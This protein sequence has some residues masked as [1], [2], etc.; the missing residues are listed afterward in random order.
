M[1]LMPLL[2]E[3]LWRSMACARSR[4]EFGLG[5]PID[6]VPHSHCTSVRLVNAAPGLFADPVAR[7]GQIMNAQ[8]T[9]P[10]RHTFATYTVDL[11]LDDGSTMS[12]DISCATF[13]SLSVGDKVEVQAQVGL[14]AIPWCLGD[15]VLPGSRQPPP[16]V[17]CK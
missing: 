10:K 3:R 12:L 5:R 9:K 17:R 1:S 15:C 2:S 7:H 4:C 6:L 13:Y 16:Y 14:L 8:V 11:T